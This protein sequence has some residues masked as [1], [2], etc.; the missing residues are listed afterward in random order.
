MF[1][2]NRNA[3]MLVLI[4]FTIN[5]LAWSFN[6]EVLADWLDHEQ[7]SGA[8]ADLKTDSERGPVGHSSTHCNHGCHAAGHL[9]GQVSY[10]LTVLSPTTA[11]TPD[12]VYSLP[13]FSNRSSQ[14]YRPPR[15]NPLA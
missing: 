13:A 3:A 8:L 12:F 14:L 11:A 9:Q 1:W 2:T 4:V 7:T 15:S 6:T 10:V 5:L